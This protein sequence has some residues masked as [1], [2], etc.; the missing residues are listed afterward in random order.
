MGNTDEP[1]S[2][3]SAALQTRHQHYGDDHPEYAKRLAS[4]GSIYWRGGQLDKA[5]PVL[6]RSL[7]I[8]RA[9]LP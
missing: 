1:D 7:E 6:R 4:L 2:L 8:R 3:L 9:S 5:E